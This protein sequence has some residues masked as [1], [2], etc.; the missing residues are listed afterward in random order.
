MALGGGDQRR[1]K[2]SAKRNSIL[3]KWRA[4]LTA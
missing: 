4:A 3:A 2:L 1:R